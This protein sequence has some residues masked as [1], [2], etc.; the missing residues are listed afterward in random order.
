M[1]A[2]KAAVLLTAGCLATPAALCSAQLAITGVITPWSGKRNMSALTSDMAMRNR[3]G[4]FHGSLLGEFQNR[5][6]F[7]PSVSRHVAKQVKT[8]ANL[9]GKPVCSIG[10]SRLKIL[11]AVLVEC[12]ASTFGVFVANQKRLWPWHRIEPFALAAL[13]GV[14][15]G[16]ISFA[17]GK[18][19]SLFPPG[20][21]GQEQS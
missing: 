18:D 16:C 8:V 11:A 10:S 17:V 7:L 6:G 21:V 2:K 1:L 12:P 9:R 14:N 19:Y 20:V 5:E 13:I 3:C 15:D 4:L